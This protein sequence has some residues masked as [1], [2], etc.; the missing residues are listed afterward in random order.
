MIDVMIELDMETPGLDIDAVVRAAAESALAHQNAQGSVSVCIVDDQQIWALNRQYRDVDRP[1]DVLS[2]P[3][4]DGEPIA[5]E[6]DGFLGD[7]VISLPAALRQAEEYGHSALRELSFLTVHGTLH[8]LGYD[9][10]TEPQS[11]EMFALQAQI[12]EDMEIKR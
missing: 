7:I 9:H 1:T 12:L 8:L 3:S 4:Q 6:P 2:F 10:I 11:R 5:A